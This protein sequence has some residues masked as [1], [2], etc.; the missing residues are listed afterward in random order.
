MADEKQ[1]PSCDFCFFPFVV[2]SSKN[3]KGFCQPYRGIACARFLGNQSI[4][5][6]S[7][8]TQGER[9]NRITGESSYE[10]PLSPRYFRH[11]ANHFLSSSC[12]HNDRHLHPP[13]GSVLQVCHPVLLLLRLPA[14]WRKLAEPEA[15]AA[16]SGRVRGPGEWPLPRGVLHRQVQPHDPHAAGAPTLPPAASARH[17]WG[18]FLYQDRGAPRKTGLT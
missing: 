16:L 2:F 6:E 1:E 11:R 10:T 5:V 3:N 18:C 13:V 4:Y 14:V 17:A 15:A 8:Q 9:E 7:L 12:L